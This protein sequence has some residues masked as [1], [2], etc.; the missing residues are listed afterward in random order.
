MLPCQG[1]CHRFESGHPLR[2]M[3]K[4]K[5]PQ[6]L[7]DELS[8]YTLAH[9]DPAFI[10]QE[11]VDAFA[12]QNADDETKPITLT[13]ALI[14]LYLYLDQNC[15]GRQVQI[16]HM[17]LAR[18]NKKWPVFSLPKERGEITVSDVLITKPGSERDAMIKKWCQ[19]VWK[20]YA[21]S[22]EQVKN[23]IKNI[24]DKK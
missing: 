24:L 22:H 10:H 6:E 19:S 23:L 21:E 16:M 8:Y 4:P 7:Y 1:R 5:S 17:R 3:D 15:T 2:I 13:F 9:R 14:G 12:A 20:A 11:I 18:L